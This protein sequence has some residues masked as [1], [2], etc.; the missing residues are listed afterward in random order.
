MSYRSLEEWN[1]RGRQVIKGQK[2]MGKLN[3]NTPLFGKEQTKKFSRIHTH[4]N[5]TKGWDGW[6]REYDQETG[7]DTGLPGQW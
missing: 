6:D 2:A 1:A 3:D 4:N 7:I 5:H